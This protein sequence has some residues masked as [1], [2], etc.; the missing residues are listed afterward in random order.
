MNEE[1]PPD[2]LSYKDLD[3]ADTAQMQG[4]VPPIAA[5]QT[6]RSSD[7]PQAAAAEAISEAHA[8]VATISDV[9]R[10]SEQQS[11]ADMSSMHQQS[12]GQL[13]AAQASRAAPEGTVDVLGGQDAISELDVDLANA[14][15]QPQLSAQ[16]QGVTADE[17]MNA[18]PK[19]KAGRPRKTSDSPKPRKKPGRPKKSDTAT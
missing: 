3:P 15:A 9:A 8:E 4:P 2:F 18:K 17:D 11:A 1:E 6:A 16:Q 5:Q 7:V 12:V 19:K 10:A 13:D 14:Q